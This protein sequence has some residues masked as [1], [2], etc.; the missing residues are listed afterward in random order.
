MN[1][2]AAS[3]ESLCDYADNLRAEHVSWEGVMKRLRAADGRGHLRELTLE[4]LQAWHAASQ[5]RKFREQTARER[6]EVRMDGDGEGLRAEAGDLRL[7][8]FASGFSPQVSG[9]TEEDFAS[10]SSPQVSGIPDR[11]FSDEVRELVKYIGGGL[12]AH[13]GQWQFARHRVL[14]AGE[15]FE[16]HRG[17]GELEGVRW[18]LG[19]V[20][21]WLESGGNREL[22]EVL[23]EHRVKRVL[24]ACPPAHY[25]PTLR[26]NVFSFENLRAVKVCQQLLEIE[27]RLRAPGL[28]AARRKAM[29]CTLR[30]LECK[31]AFAGEKTG[32]T[33][34]KVQ[35][36]VSRIATT[37]HLYLPKGTTGAKSGAEL[38]RA[39]NRTRAAVSA[40]KLKRG[41]EDTV[42]TGGSAGFDGMRA[43]GRHR[44]KARGEMGK[45]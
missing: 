39:I 42:K 5:K 16:R 4:Q 45:S 32:V 26:L 17:A 11:S 18:K 3:I 8:D 9:H 34:L 22:V 13:R 28:S 35:E 23:A 14:R 30:R 31:A 44:E 1:L 29:E 27:C 20:S 33:V 41:E 36:I 43:A 38:G 40:A 6:R 24:P 15:T 2:P 19:A 37:M 7:G 10:G 12:V 25:H 21:I